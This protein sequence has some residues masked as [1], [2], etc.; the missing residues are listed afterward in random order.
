MSTE[1]ERQIRAVAKVIA[2]LAPGTI[3]ILLAAGEDM[4]DGGIRQSLPAETVPPDL[5]SPNS[6]FIVV[7]DRDSL[8]IVGVERLEKSR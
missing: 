5:R 3:D 4:A 7:V 8:D 1:S 2:A 6:E